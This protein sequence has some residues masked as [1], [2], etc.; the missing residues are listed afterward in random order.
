V[1][2]LRSLLR[3]RHQNPTPQQAAHALADGACLYAP[4]STCSGRPVPVGLQDN[5]DMEVVLCCRAHYGRLRQLDER[6][7]NQ[8]RN[9]LRDGFVRAA[10]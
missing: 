2:S 4:V 6:K 8:L 9:H 10:P 7:R 3:P 1:I 5:D